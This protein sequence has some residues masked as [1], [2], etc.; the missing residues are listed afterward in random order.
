M[1]VQE[2]I[3]HP[4]T[5]DVTFRRPYRH[6]DV[7][8]EGHALDPYLERTVCLRAAITTQISICERRIVGCRRRHAANHDRLA[9]GWP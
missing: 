4:G 2:A 8:W 6:P 1:Y 5:W 3:K 7:V 9:S